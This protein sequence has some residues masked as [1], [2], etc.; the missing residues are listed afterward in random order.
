MHNYTG[1]SRKCALLKHTLYSQWSHW[2]AVPWWYLLHLSA[3]LQV[4][5]FQNCEFWVILWSISHNNDIFYCYYLESHFTV[6]CLFPC[7]SAAWRYAGYQLAY[8]I[9]GKRKATYCC[10]KC[11]M[12]CWYDLIIIHDQVWDKG[13]FHTKWC[14]SYKQI[15]VE[16]NLVD[17]QIWVARDTTIP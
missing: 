7:Q 15:W 5:C 6:A 17:L 1:I 10:M 9:T 8:L 13:A 14:S 12:K 4:L 16:V 3:F 2:K 11:F